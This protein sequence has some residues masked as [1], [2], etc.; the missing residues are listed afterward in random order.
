MKTKYKH[1]RFEEVN[2]KGSYRCRSLNRLISYGY[3]TWSDHHSCFVFRP[4]G[5]TEFSGDRLA[6]IQ[7]FIGQLKHD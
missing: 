5:Y 7:H 2:T 3:V 4:D 1:F 6:D